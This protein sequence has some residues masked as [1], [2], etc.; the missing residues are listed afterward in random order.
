MHSTRPV[1]L[2]N[3]KHDTTRPTTQTTSFNPAHFRGAGSCVVWPVPIGRTAAIC[4]GRRGHQQ[5]HPTSSSNHRTSIPLGMD[6]RMSISKLRI[7]PWASW[8]T[9]VHIP[10]E[11]ATGKRG[12]HSSER[13]GP[14]AVPI[15]IT[16]R[17]VR[18]QPR[19][20]PGPAP[21]PVRWHGRGADRAVFCPGT[22]LVHAN[23]E[24][25]WV[26]GDKSQTGNPP[27]LRQDVEGTS[28]PRNRR[29]VFSPL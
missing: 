19:P 1:I 20:G 22:L 3:S 5:H 10:P 4:L 25:S 17:L 16:Q 12:S 13:L 14:T 2:T 18:D 15:S 24:A 28:R 26:L 27:S 11:P 9:T 23:A 29:S 6:E 7:S 21:V 8:P